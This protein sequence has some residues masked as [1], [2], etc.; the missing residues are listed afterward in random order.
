M[1]LTTH[2][3][4]RVLHEA[5]ITGIAHRAGDDWI[6]VHLTHDHEVEHALGILSA[7]GFVAVAS[8][9]LP[10]TVNVTG[11]RIGLQDPESLQVGDEV[12]WQRAARSPRYRL[13]IARVEKSAE[14][15]DDGTLVEG[16]AWLEAH[17]ERVTYLRVLYAVGDRADVTRRA[18]M[19]VRP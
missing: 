11:L 5:E 8:D 17:P 3:V 7:S 4:T 19:P 18:E 1:N 9:L 10:G 2:A 13:Q 6:R 16:L 15:L 14:Y 12:R